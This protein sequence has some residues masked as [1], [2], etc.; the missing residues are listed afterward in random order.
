MVKDLDPDPNMLRNR[1]IDFTLSTAGLRIRLDLLIDPDPNVEKAGSV[2]SIWYNLSSFS[3]NVK[4]NI[5]EMI[6]IL[7]HSLGKPQK[8][9]VF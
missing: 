9:F 4:L 7:Y 8:K 6:L 2:Y 3:W 5:I 1:N